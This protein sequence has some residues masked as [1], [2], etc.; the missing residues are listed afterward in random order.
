MRNIK[1]RIER[2][3]REKTPPASDPTVILY[4]ALTPGN[5]DP[6]DLDPT[7][8]FAGSGRGTVVQRRLEESL[9]DMIDRIS[10]E[11]PQ[12]T[13]WTGWYRSVR[14]NGTHEGSSPKFDR[15]QS[16]NTP[17]AVPISVPLT[18]NPT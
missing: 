17:E 2:L 4:R 8:L 7:E 5:L 18:R 12:V 15:E 11:Y 9:D 1:N 10:R 13:V 16:Q 3:E 6:V 14:E